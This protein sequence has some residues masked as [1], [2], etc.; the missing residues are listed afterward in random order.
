MGSKYK[1]NEI[2]VQGTNDSSIVSKCSM[3]HVG[4]FK[5]VFLEHFVQKK[6]RRSPLINRG[7]YV[8]A[9]AMD[10][11]INL[12]LQHYKEKKKQIISLGAGFDSCYF[13][14][15]DK[16]CLSN[17]RYLELD[18]PEVVQ[19]KI[20][21]IKSRKALSSLV[22]GITA[23]Q[24]EF[25][26]DDYSIVGCDLTNLDRL[27]EV[28]RKANFNPED[29][30]LLFSEVVLTYVEKKGCSR[31]IEWAARTFQNSVFILYEQI[32]PDDAFGA[33]M[34][35]HFETLQSPLRCIREYPTL[36]SQIQRFK[37]L[38]WQRCNAMDMNEFYHN[39]VSQEERNHVEDIESFDEFEEWHLK[40]AHYVLVAAFTGSC[41]QLEERMF[42]AVEKN[43][44]NCPKAE[45]IISWKS[46][47]ESMECFK[48]FGHELIR[49]ESDILFLN[50]GFGCSSGKHQRLGDGVVLKLNQDK[51]ANGF[52]SF[53]VLPSNRVFHTTTLLSDGSIF[54]FGGRESPLKPCTD[55]GIFRLDIK[56]DC[57]NTAEVVAASYSEFIW[58]GAIRKAAVSNDAVTRVSNDTKDDPKRYEATD[59]VEQPCCRWRHCAVAVCI[60]GEEYVLILGGR[61][62]MKDTLS[63][64]W[65]FHTKKHKWRKVCLQSDNGI[66]KARH[67]HSICKW[68]SGKLI[69]SGGLDK[70]SQPMNQLE[71]IHLQGV[72][73]MFLETV[74]FENSLPPRYSHTSHVVG[75]ELW[76]VGGVAFEIIPQFLVI[77]PQKR[78]WKE[79]QWQEKNSTNSTLMLHNHAS[80]LCRDE[81]LV[82]G[83]G[84]NCFSF[85]THFNKGIISIKVPETFLMN[86]D[87]V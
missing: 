21:L 34:L 64:C 3:A 79:Y 16:A 85:G 42:A 51:T 77:N 57:G 38:G 50:G 36:D 65:L 71:I 83:G 76:L 35:K 86:S 20:K 33:V 67:S 27:Q 8:R 73:E 74:Q 9:R 23:N 11:A 10:S 40:C 53:P 66:V 80:V 6:A 5:D 43:R 45:S 47:N 26:S 15:K 30:T 54:L 75:D 60:A 49:L 18:F 14:L 2:N 7:Y 84:G 24:N 37:T 12:F 22:D 32:Q 87:N 41:C 70:D 82:I 63:D 59:V 46:T 48:R 52:Y 72:D 1:G 28:I 13:R 29:F 25:I 4:Y 56:V 39:I 78:Y 68:G 17:T 81:I 58:K 31:L 19:R 61:N 44:T 69:V 55:Y 62:E